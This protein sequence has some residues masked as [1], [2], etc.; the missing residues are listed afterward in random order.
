MHLDA[1]KHTDMTQLNSLFWFA[2]N[3]IKE[4]KTDDAS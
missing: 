1:R 2:A 4:V 3:C